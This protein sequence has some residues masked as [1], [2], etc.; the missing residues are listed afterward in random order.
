[1]IPFIISVPVNFQAS[2]NYRGSTQLAVDRLKTIGQGKP[3][4]EWSREKP[5]RMYV[6]SFFFGVVARISV[7]TGEVD[8]YCQLAAFHSLRKLIHRVWSPFVAWILERYV[9]S[10]S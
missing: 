7:S 4:E 6:H 8:E 1:M 10:H 3:R 9:R 2:L 5:G